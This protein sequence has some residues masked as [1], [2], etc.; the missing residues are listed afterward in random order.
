MVDRVKGDFAGRMSQ[1][2]NQ[3]RSVEKNTTSFNETMASKANSAERPVSKEPRVNRR[4]GNKEGSASHG[5]HSA[6]LA[7]TGARPRLSKCITKVQAYRLAQYAP[8]IQAASRRYKVPVELICGV[9]LQESGG[10]ASALSH[11][12]ATG[13]M[14]LMPGTAR[15]MGVSNIY[16][17]GQNIMGGTKYLRFLLDRFDG[18]ITL[19]VA[20]YN[21]GEGNVEKYGRKIPPFS[22][23][24][25][26]VPNVLK[27]ADTLWTLLRSSPAARP[28]N[29]ASTPATAPAVTHH[30]T[31]FDA[32]K[33][34]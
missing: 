17:P 12:G 2:V 19:A 28:M 11:C 3:R 14:Q 25:A 20:G 8:L 16:D 32:K 9:I 22:E 4:L 21:A 23:T 10:R 27:Y 15:R 29:T 13:L 31:I 6:S 18:N 1:Y 5:A 30:N 24:R 33:R 26:Y 34:V 7:A